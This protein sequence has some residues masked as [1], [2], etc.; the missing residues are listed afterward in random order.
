MRK[1]AVIIL[2]PELLSL[3]VWHAARLCRSLEQPEMPTAHY[4]AMEFGMLFSIVIG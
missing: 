3:L 1:L 4:R 2:L